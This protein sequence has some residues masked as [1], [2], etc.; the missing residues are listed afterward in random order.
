MLCDVWIGERSRVL[1]IQ[2]SN[3]LAGAPPTGLILGDNQGCR[4]DDGAYSSGF[5]EPM[6]Q[7][8]GSG[9]DRPV[10]QIDAGTARRRGVLTL[11]RGP[12]EPWTV[13]GQDGRRWKPGTGGG[14]VTD[15]RRAGE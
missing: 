5:D 14:G 8:G 7:S 9:V 2:K 4:R 10:V 1:P 13:P 15:L 11:G 6:V 12:T 3:G